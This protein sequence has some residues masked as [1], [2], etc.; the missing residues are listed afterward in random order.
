MDILHPFLTA[1]FMGTPAW[2]WLA[3]VGIVVGLLAGSPLEAL[4]APPD[5]P[6]FR[7]LSLGAWC[8]FLSLLLNLT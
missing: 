2:I 4:L 3:F 5:W 8:I 1:D 6:A 7:E